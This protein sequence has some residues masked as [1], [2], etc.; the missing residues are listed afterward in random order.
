MFYRSDALPVSEPTTSQHWG[1]MNYLHYRR[2][3]KP[4]VSGV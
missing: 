2:K 4:R 1:I 3:K